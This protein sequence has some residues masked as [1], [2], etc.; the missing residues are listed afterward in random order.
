MAEEKRIYEPKVGQRI[1]PEVAERQKRTYEILSDPDIEWVDSD[2][3]RVDSEG[4][5][6]QEEDVDN[7]SAD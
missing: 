5:P 1:P 7:R 6:L 2:G 3:R 4:E